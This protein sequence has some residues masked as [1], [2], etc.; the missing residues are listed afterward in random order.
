MKHDSNL[1]D[2]KLKATLKIFFFLIFVEFQG[3]P[4][5]PGSKK[6]SSRVFQGTGNPATIATQN[7]TRKCKLK[8]QIYT[9]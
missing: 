1:N 4:G 2:R 6:K 5:F 9:S 7:L 8:I 3:F